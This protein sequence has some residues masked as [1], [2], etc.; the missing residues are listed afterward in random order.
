MAGRGN[1]VRGVDFLFSQRLRQLTLLMTAVKHL[2]YSLLDDESDEDDRQRRRRTHLRKP[3]EN[4]R[5][6]L[7][8]R[9]VEHILRVIQAPVLL[10]QS[11]IEAGRGA[12]VGNAAG[13]LQGKRVR[14]GREVRRKEKVTHR[15]ASTGQNKDV[16][17]LPDE[18]DDVLRCIDVFEFVAISEAASG[19]EE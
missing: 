17:A 7:E 10:L 6:L 11:S 1:E 2:H 3:V 9:Q 8:I 15:Y 16:F 4:V 12:E 19:V 18:L 5:F 13:G 14:K